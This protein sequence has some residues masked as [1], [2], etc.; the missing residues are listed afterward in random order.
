MSISNTSGPVTVTIDGIDDLIER[1]ES[2]AADE[3]TRAIAQEAE[4]IA[5][6]ARRKWYSEV[7]RETG[8]SGDIRTLVTQRDGGVVVS[9]GSTDLSRES[10]SGRRRV[11]VIHARGDSEPLIDVLV[12]KP[13]S[14]RL[15]KVAEVAA[16]R[17]KAGMS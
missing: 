7:D 5:Q 13:M 1:L 10:G 16:R 3:V 17:I 2:V 6:N 4:R 14:K 15:P 12:V 11:R 8:R 9:V